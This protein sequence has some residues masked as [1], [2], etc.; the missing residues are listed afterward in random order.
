VIAVAEWEAS[1]GA[2]ASLLASSSQK[3]YSEKSGYGLLGFDLVALP[4]A[5]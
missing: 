1:F 4:M 5:F 2:A 3:E